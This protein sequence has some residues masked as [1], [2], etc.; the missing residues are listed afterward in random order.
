M[1][2]TVD[3]EVAS[4]ESIQDE[5][6]RVLKSPGFRKCFQLSRFLRFTVEQALSG[7]NGASKECLIGMQIFGRP[8]D[9]DPGCDP[10]VR[11]EARRLRRKLAEYYEG[12]G[13]FDR[14]CI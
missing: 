8:A 6:E 14:V 13:R 12:D 5:L 11:V 3:T 1:D 10:I 9:Y 2:Y 4:R 7:Q